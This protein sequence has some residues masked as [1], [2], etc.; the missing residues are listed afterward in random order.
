MHKEMQAGLIG[1]LLRAC[2]R[3]TSHALHSSCFGRCRDEDEA[4]EAAD[5]GQHYEGHLVAHIKVGGRGRRA[6]DVE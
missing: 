4:A 1:Q 2:L 5:A 6:A 3:C